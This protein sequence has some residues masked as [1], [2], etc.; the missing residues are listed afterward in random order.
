MGQTM[1]DVFISYSRSDKAFVQRLFAQLEA[2]GYDA[3]VDWD[4]I[5]YADDWWHTI[6]QGIEGADT[7]VFIMSPASARSK[8]CF[9]E[10]EHAAQNNKRIVPVVLT[11]VDEKA[12]QE[13]LHPALKRHNWL[14]FRAEDDFEATFATLLETVRRDPQHVQMHTRLLVRAHDWQGDGENASAL[15]RGDALTQA[16]QWLAQADGKDPAPTTLHHN[17]IQRSRAHERRR[18][19]QT[20]GAGLTALLALLLVGG[21]A[22]ALYSQT[23]RDAQ[24]QASLE[25]AAEAVTA[26][27][28]GAVTEALTLALAANALDDPP[29]EAQAVLAQVAASPGPIAQLSHTSAATTVAL[30]PDGSRILAGY[31]DGTLRLWDATSGIGQFDTALHV[32]ETTHSE[33]VVSLV[34]DPTGQYAASV[35][36][37]ARDDA[38]ACV[39]G[40]LFIWEVVA[41]A[42]ILRQDFDYANSGERYYDERHFRTSFNDITF[43]PAPN[44]RNSIEVMLATDYADAPVSLRYPLDDAVDDVWPRPYALYW[45]WDR[46]LP[47]EITALAINTR[48]DRVVSGSIRGL[49]ILHQSAN[50]SARDFPDLAA[51]VTTIAPSFVRGSGEQFLAGDT[52]GNLLLGTQNGLEATWQ[53]GSTVAG[54]A[55]ARDGRFDLVAL[56]D[57]RLV[58]LDS[59]GQTQTWRSANEAALTDLALPMADDAPLIAVVAADDGTLTLWDFAAHD[60]PQADLVAW[61]RENRYV[62]TAE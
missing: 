11:D 7:F 58:Q 59:V 48:G 57:G 25:T 52:E 19:A 36:C 18:R 51:R 31:A 24:V 42:L 10:V 43:D 6:E 49:M 3:W 1:S 34:F 60:L 38:E 2:E 15:L 14:L 47:N 30:V 17:Y 54:I 20:L 40:E 28:A 46:R 32:S 45:N 61:L 56:A 55:S 35:S 37:G 4:D 39:D 50:S 26:L 22:F 21:I 13:R 44:I 29:R 41:D 12:D 53:L 16:E 23:Q 8:I 27:E 9:D 33:G 62:S 5:A